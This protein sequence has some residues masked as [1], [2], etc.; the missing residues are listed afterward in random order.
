MVIETG[1]TC[2]E[3]AV[4]D[5][6]HAQMRYARLLSIATRAGSTDNLILGDVMLRADEVAGLSALHLSFE[7]PETP[8]FPLDRTHQSRL[9]R[10]S[11]NR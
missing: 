3:I 8:A 2:V 10:L 11:T 4:C 6:P 1:L 7:S 9:L 5:L